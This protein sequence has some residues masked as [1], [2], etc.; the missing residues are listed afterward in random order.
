MTNMMQKMKVDPNFTPCPVHEDDEIFPNGIFEF[1][2]TRIVDY[3]NTT[4]PDVEV[5]EV[6][7]TDLDQ[8]FSTLNESHVESVDITRPVVLAE[9]SPGHY[10]L[11]DG[12]HRVEKD[13]RQGVDTIRACKLTAAQHIRFLTSTK[14][15]LSYVEYW[16]GKVKQRGQTRTTEPHQPTRPRAPRALGGRR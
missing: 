16:N 1:N 5:A 2:V 9:I 3:L 12:H 11:I 15:Y 14:A 7:V 10:N 6:A 8:G 4:P 13:R